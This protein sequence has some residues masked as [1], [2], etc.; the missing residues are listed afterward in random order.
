[1]G[2]PHY[3]KTRTFYDTRA[4]DNEENK[5]KGVHF[6]VDDYR[7]NGIYDNPER[8]FERYPQYAFLLSPDFSTYADMDLWRQLESVAKNRWV[9]AYWQS[10]G[11]TVIPTVSW[12]DA[13]SFEF[14]FDGVEQGSIVA[15]GMVGCKQ[16]KFQFMRGYNEM[17]KRI[18]PSKVICFGTPFPEMKGNI[19]AVDY[20]ASRKVV[21]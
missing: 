10:K 1:M 7:F 4:N 18:Q 3:P 19:I 21:R 14:C 2:D 13:R 9:G 5:K 12:S 8:T 17:L 11:M 20:M 16:A 6:F 15:I